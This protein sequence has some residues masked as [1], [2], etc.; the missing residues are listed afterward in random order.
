VEQGSRVETVDTKKDGGTRR[1]RG[2]AAGT[3]PT[4]SSYSVTSGGLDHLTGSHKDGSW[5]TSTRAQTS[6]NQLQAN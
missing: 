1:F 4:V 3:T 5:M 6:G 2:K